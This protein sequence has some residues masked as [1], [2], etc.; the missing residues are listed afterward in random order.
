MAPNSPHS[1]NLTPQMFVFV[2]WNRFK[3]LYVTRLLD[4]P[5]PCRISRASRKASQWGSRRPPSKYY[6]GPY[7]LSSAASHNS[8]PTSSPKGAKKIFFWLCG[9]KQ[10]SLWRNPKNVF[11]VFILFEDELLKSTRCFFTLAQ[12]GSVADDQWKRIPEHRYAI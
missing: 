12:I 11:G 10:L 5:H 7:P 8:A 9:R 6:A 2:T 4:M 3:L 1:F